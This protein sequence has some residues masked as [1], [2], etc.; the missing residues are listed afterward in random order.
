MPPGVV[1][2]NGAGRYG[3]WPADCRAADARP[4]ANARSGCSRPAIATRIAD[5]DAAAE[6]AHQAA[7]RGALGQDV[8]RQGRQRDVLSGVKV[9]PRPKPCSSPEMMTGPGPICSEKPVI[10]HSDAAVS[11]KPGQDDQP[12]VDPVDQPR[13]DEHREH[14]ADAARRGDEA[15]GHHR[16]VHHCC[17]IVG[18][19][20]IVPVMMPIRNISRCRRRNWA[21]QQLAV[22][23]RAV[24]RR[25]RCGR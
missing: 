16:I 9:Q 6:I 4:A 3:A 11:R 8:A 18:S 5:A 17:S 12:V 19:S 25:S 20:A 22:Q 15:G 21:L 24:G 1:R 2:L 14:R 7:D 13:H 23:E 10:C